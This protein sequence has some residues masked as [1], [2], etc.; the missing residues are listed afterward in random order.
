MKKNKPYAVFF[1]FFFLFLISSC[2]LAYDNSKEIITEF[3]PDTGDMN[4]RESDRKFAGSFKIETKSTNADD[5]KVGGSVKDI[6]VA[7]YASW[8]KNGTYERILSDSFTPVD[9]S[10]NIITS[11]TFSFSHK[12]PNTWSNP[13]AVIVVAKFNSTLGSSP[14]TSFDGRGDVYKDMNLETPPALTNVAIGYGSTYYEGLKSF[15]GSLG[16]I[17]PI[18]GKVKIGM[19][20][21]VEIKLDPR[22]R[23]D[24]GTG[25]YDP[26]PEGVGVFADLTGGTNPTTRIYG[27][28]KLAGEYYKSMSPKKLPFDLPFYGEW[29]ADA[30]TPGVIVGGPAMAWGAPPV[31]GQNSTWTE[32]EKVIW[33]LPPKKISFTPDINKNAEGKFEIYDGQSFGA[34][35]T[36]ELRKLQIQSR[37]SGFE[38]NWG[39][40]TTDKSDKVNGKMTSHKSHTYNLNN[41]EVGQEF[42]GY[43]I[44]HYQNS[45]NNSTELRYPFTVKVKPLPSI[46]PKNSI[47]VKRE[48]GAGNVVSELVK[49]D[50]LYNFLGTGRG[51]RLVTTEE[52]KNIYSYYFTITDPIADPS[53]ITKNTT[54]KENP[55]INHKFKYVAEEHGQIYEE[56]YKTV[57]LYIKY[58]EGAI[59]NGELVHL[60]E[61][62]KL[63]VTRVFKLGA[64]DIDGNNRYICFNVKPASYTFPIITRNLSQIEPYKPDYF[65][66]SCAV[67]TITESLQRVTMKFNASATIFYGGNFE[68]EN[69]GELDRFDGVATN[70]VYYRWRVL[71][72]DGEDAFE[73]G[74]A[75]VDK[76]EYALISDF[77]EKPYALKDSNGRPYF[78]NNNGNPIIESNAHTT[79]QTNLLRDGTL[80]YATESEFPHGI[81]P[82]TITFK[83]PYGNSIN[84]N[85]FYKVFVEAKY[86]D[87]KWNTTKS[88]SL[89]DEFD[90]SLNAKLRFSSTKGQRY[91]VHQPCYRFRPE[92]NYYNLVSDN[93][94][95]LKIEPSYGTSNEDFTFISGYVPLGKEQYDV[96]C[97][98]SSGALVKINNQV[99]ATVSF[100]NDSD[101]PLKNKAFT[102]DPLFV[103]K[104]TENIAN[105][106]KSIS[107][108]IDSINPDVIASY[109]EI[110][111]DRFDE[112]NY[113]MVP[114]KSSVCDLDLTKDKLSDYVEKTNGS[115]E[116]NGSLEDVAKII[117]DSINKKGYLTASQK[118]D[119]Y[120]FVLSSLEKY[121][122]NKGT[123][124]YHSS[125][126]A[127]YSDKEERFPDSF[128]TN[129]RAPNANSVDNEYFNAGKEILYGSNKHIINNTGRFNYRAKVYI[130]NGFKHYIET[131]VASFTVLDNDIPNVKITLVSPDSGN[132]TL[133][134]IFGGFND[135]MNV[136][137]AKATDKVNLAP[138]TYKLTI[139]DKIKRNEEINETTK[140]LD[141]N[142]IATTTVDLTGNPFE[143]SANERFL[144]NIQVTDNVLPN[145][146]DNFVING[147]LSGNGVDEIYDKIKP[148]FKE[149]LVKD[150]SGK[151][152]KVYTAEVPYYI[153]ITQPGENYRLIFNIL[154]NGNKKA[155]ELFLNVK[156]LKEKKAVIRVLDQQH[157]KK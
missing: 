147:K 83:V 144:C 4:E 69:T 130:D 76:S 22:T 63:L 24:G 142:E 97:D 26:T 48:D 49:E 57:R 131:D 106:G 133:V 113:R 12:N 85:R 115:F 41:P 93:N 42:N 98:Y 58:H 6:N 8:N 19:T 71:T 108:K 100:K 111:Y 17:D 30:N 59:V 65:G 56:P 2:L 92:P 53:L 145:T 91:I 88:E 5:Y 119:K 94:G 51:A 36:V 139:D 45:T 90:N 23:S 125:Y 64:Q 110:I 112:D 101:E 156:V 118:I 129:M 114:M 21:L 33:Y 79:G 157:E 124:Q 3:V 150:A 104:N 121:N 27:A 95:K 128:A 46:Y 60:G 149:S 136:Y 43:C 34:N 25:A 152:K 138:F 31:L 102:G 154:D 38:W 137:T 141:S 18:T 134:E 140:E 44:I 16:T 80:R 52:H 155:I 32:Q 61:K 66:E 123:N 1:L 153:S 20:I 120:P 87:L 62:T 117:F 143:V 11:K 103:D 86:Q 127:L 99:R 89:L 50:L 105:I 72:A 54:S 35:A 29:E 146:N 135:P 151:N 74:Y 116:T 28:T 39:D 148:E 55:S 70:T 109:V 96:V 10:G 15:D 67:G 14:S 47:Q 132:A 84:P 78:I 126:V 37:I 40:G 68:N 77:N 13:M 75:E 81:K 7:V 82:I 73:K 9:G 107:I 122:I